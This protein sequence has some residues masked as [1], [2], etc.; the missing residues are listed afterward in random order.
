MTESGTRAALVTGASRG[1]GRAIAVEL[2]A[3]GWEIGI[4][5]ARNRP[6]AEETAAAVAAKGRRAVLCPG[7]LAIRADREAILAGLADKLKQGDKALVGNKG[8]RKYLKAHGRRFEID[9]QKVRDEA[10][11]DGKWVLRTNW[12][13]ADAAEVALR[14]KEL[15]MVEAVLRQVKSVLETRP[16]YHK[17]DDTIRGHVFCSFLALVLLKE[18]QG[19]LEACSWHPEWERLKDDLEALEEITVANAGKTLV[20]RSQTRGDAGKALQA[21]G[22]ALGPT[23][24]LAE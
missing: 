14:Y 23:I 12:Q 15:W 17:C 9:Q 21:A 18:L 2:A 1:I 11:F 20:I 13:E 19:R 10:R 8:F 6:A 22:V 16:V 24:R 7:D 4:G 5:F 3:S